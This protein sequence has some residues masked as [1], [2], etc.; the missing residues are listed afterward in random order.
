[1]LDVAQAICASVSQ[2]VTTNLEGVH[3]YWESKSPILA[4]GLL[5]EAE[6]L[7]SYRCTGT[8]PW[9][10]RSVLEDSRLAGCIGDR[11]KGQ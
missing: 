1:M 5:L 9:T 4:L 2:T 11:R 3:P 8:S 6:E 10:R 7:Q